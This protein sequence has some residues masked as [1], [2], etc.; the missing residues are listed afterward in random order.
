MHFIYTLLIALVN[1]LDNIGVRIA[2]SIRGIKIPHLKNLWISIITFIISS[3]AAFS[4]KLISIIVTQKVASLLSM[5]ILTIVGICIVLE[6][7]MKARKK[8]S[9]TDSTHKKDSTKNSTKDSSEDISENCTSNTIFKILENP[10]IADIDK[11]KTIDFKESTLLGIALSINNIGGSLGAGVI[12]IN[13]ILIG[14]LSAIISFIVLWAGN[15]LIQF[16][17]KW[18][19]QNK[20]NLLAG[21]ILIMLGIKQ[22]I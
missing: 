19:L 9:I 20:F 12:G 14:L 11:S 21:V 2:Y 10:E 6:P 5:I 16:L 3:T 22:I 18:K 13:S 7:H 1:N 8:S 4:G 17:Y 15:Y